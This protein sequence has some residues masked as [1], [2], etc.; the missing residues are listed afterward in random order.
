MQLNAYRDY[1]EHVKHCEHLKKN[2]HPEKKPES[3][4]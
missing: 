1:R 2:K 4:N 3:K